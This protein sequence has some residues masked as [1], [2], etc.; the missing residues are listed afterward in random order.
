MIRVLVVD[1]QP[2]VAG[3]QAA[4]VNRVEGFEANAVAHDG[5]AA[6]AAA[7]RG[8]FDL[9]LLDLAMPGIDGLE[10]S[11]RLQAL[12]HPPDVIIVTA[13]R[14]LESVR[15]A[16]RCGALLYLIKPFTFAGLRTKLEQYAAYRERSHGDEVALNQDEVDS[17]L[18]ALRQSGI[19]PLPKGLAQETLRAVRQVLREEPEGRSAH[20]VADAVGASRVTARRYLEHLVTSGSCGR[21]LRHGTAGRPE[22][23]YRCDG[24]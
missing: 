18:G 10:T 4:L 3:A 11:R 23:V 12:P 24:G 22:V 15:T 14:D 6:L 21:T 1:D 5:H 2:I 17:T 7:R 16:I 8:T 9:V 13:A 20:E 19:T